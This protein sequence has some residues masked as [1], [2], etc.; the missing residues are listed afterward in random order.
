[1]RLKSVYR[2]LCLLVVVGLFCVTRPAF[3]QKFDFSCFGL[4][5]KSA[6]G[7]PQDN[8]HKYSFLGSCQ[9]YFDHSD[10]SIDTLATVPAEAQAQWDKFKLQFSESFRVLANAHFGGADEGNS[11][12]NG[13]DISNGLVQTIFRCNDDPLVTNASCLRTQHSNQSGFEEF[14]NPAFHNV[15]L[16]SGTTNL[17]EATALSKQQASKQPGQPAQP[18]PPKP[19]TPSP[20]AVKAA[21]ALKAM[22]AQKRAEARTAP[23]AAA[24]SGGK[25]PPSGLGAT[26]TL[27]GVS[28]QPGHPSQMPNGTQRSGSDVSASQTDSKTKDAAA[29]AAALRAIEAQKK[30]RQTETLKAAA[31]LAQQQHTQP[32]QSLGGLKLPPT[33]LPDLT[34]SPQVRVAGKYLAGWGQTITVSS[35]DA[36]G[37]HNGVCDFAVQHE[38]RNLGTAASGVLSSRWLDQQNPVTL[39][40]TYPPIPAGGTVQ[41]TDT[42]PLKPGLNQLTFAL[43]NL[44]QVK[45]A[46]ESN[47]IFHLTINVG[48]N[49]GSR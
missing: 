41:R 22:Q 26:R 47:N 7:V 13:G 48:G 44:D 40:S 27:Q 1:M 24:A 21:E 15:P 8:V 9:V 2:R 45:E 32:A 25:L 36:R 28:P 37:M 33:G 17:A 38:L 43:D 18:P 11:H 23:L 46:N 34:S 14:S 19:N 29:A 10:G 49:C 35:S 4:K 6:S 5:L 39:T 20:E 3:A 42:L 30:A 31:A 16:L 12:W